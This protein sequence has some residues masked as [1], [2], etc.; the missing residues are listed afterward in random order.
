MDYL[1]DPE[2]ILRVRRFMLQHGVQDSRDIEEKTG[3]SLEAAMGNDDDPACENDPL[4]M[5]W[6][7]AET[8][9]RFPNP[10]V[11]CGGRQE[12]LAEVLLL[13]DMLNISY[14]PLPQFIY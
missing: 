11:C 12:C 5:G 9:A 6:L 7:E 13:L 8:L 10:M 1:S 14:T 3:Q 2:T 4:Y